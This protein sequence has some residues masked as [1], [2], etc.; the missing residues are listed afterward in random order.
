MCSKGDMKILR[1]GVY[2]MGERLFEAVGLYACYRLACECPD[3]EDRVKRRTSFISLIASS[4]LA[5]LMFELALRRSK[6][7]RF[8]IAALL[9]D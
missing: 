6:F 5:G 4:T 9:A 1:D 2:S 7:L 8:V 3:I